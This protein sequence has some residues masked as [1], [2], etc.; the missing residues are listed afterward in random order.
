[1]SYDESA[2]VDFLNNRNLRDDEA[3]VRMIEKDEIEDNY[4]IITELF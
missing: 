3:R 4:D 2:F 1:M